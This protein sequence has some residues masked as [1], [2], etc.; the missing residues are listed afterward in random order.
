MSGVMR[1]KKSRN[2]G[3]CGLGVVTALTV[4]GSPLTS[5]RDMSF[6]HVRKAARCEE[7][8]QPCCRA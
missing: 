6:V 5:L 3:R 2:A 7:G 8:L 4:F 1:Q